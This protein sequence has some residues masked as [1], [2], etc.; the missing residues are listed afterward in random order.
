[1]YLKSCETFILFA[2][3]KTIY[4]GAKSDTIAAFQETLRAAER[5]IILVLPEIM[6]A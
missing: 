4:N 6:Q 5:I 2:E 3:D 1:M